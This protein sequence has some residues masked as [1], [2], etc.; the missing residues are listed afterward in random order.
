MAISRRQLVVSALASGFALAVRPV[1]AQSVISTDSAGLVAGEIKIPTAD[2]ELPGYRAM[3]AK[4]RNFPTVLVVQEVFGLHEHIKDLCRRFAKAGYFAISAELYA[5]QG[6]VH[7]APDLNALL[8]IVKSVPDQQ[9]LSDLDACVAY[10]RASRKADVDKLAVTGFCW[11]GRIVWLYAAHNSGLKAAAA[12]YGHVT[13]E[14]TE[15]QPRYPIDVVNELKAPVIAFYGGK[16]RGITAD[17][18]QQMRAALENVATKTELVIFP[19]AEHGFNADYRPSYNAQD[20]K[21]AWTQMLGWFK[22]FGAA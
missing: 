7:N 19:D 8:P 13:G 6:D 12:W 2:V 5:R 17:S 16:D 1:Q 4:G 22:Q 9:V 10:A 3:P 15:L 14:P 21:A 20:A 18:I 11:G